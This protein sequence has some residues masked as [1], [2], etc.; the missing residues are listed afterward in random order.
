MGTQLRAANV[1][2]E[3]SFQHSDSPPETEVGMI[4]QA[5]SRLSKKASHSRF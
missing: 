2:A 4:G 1:K 3:G 5:Y